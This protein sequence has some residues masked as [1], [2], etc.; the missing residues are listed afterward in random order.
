MIRLAIVDDHV[1]VRH[2]LREFLQGCPELEVV[3]EGHNGAQAAAIAVAA[4]PDVLLMDLVMP[5]QNG[6]DALEAIRARAPQLAVLIFSGY[7][8]EGHALDL[9][10]RGAA[11]YLH[12]NCEP[13][14]IVRAIRAVAAG[15]LYLPPQV[16]HRLGL[17]E[18]G[19]Q[20]GAGQGA[21]AGQQQ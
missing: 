11:G 9:L 6:R 12:K 5:G 4:A 18:A 7:P 1:S 16:A 21:L 17:P 10:K 20:A 2:Y 8:E 14:E 19:A 15:Q 13:D 3:A